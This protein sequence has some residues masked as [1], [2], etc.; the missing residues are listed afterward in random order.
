MSIVTCHVTHGHTW[1][2]HTSSTVPAVCHFS[3]SV[4]FLHPWHCPSLMIISQYT[5]QLQYFHMQQ[6]VVSAHVMFMCGQK[7]AT[8]HS[9]ALGSSLLNSYTS[10]NVRY[11][12]LLHLCKV[13]QESSRILD[14]GN[15]DVLTQISP[16]F[17]VLSSHFTF[18]RLLAR[19]LTYMLPLF[20]RN[21]CY[22]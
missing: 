7:K 17:K 1:H 14:W 13:A 9:I 6:A 11:A 18:L 15:K 5:L 4:S 20:L 19:V 16:T 2:H 21:V 10:Q 12:W 3:Y 22:S 8:C